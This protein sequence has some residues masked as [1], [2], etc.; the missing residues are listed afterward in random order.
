MMKK[1]TAAVL[2]VL[3]M[4]SAFVFTA[5]AE[6]IGFKASVSASLL[7]VDKGDEVSF[8]VT[9]N[10]ITAEGGLLGV[11]IPFRYDT[12]VFEFVSLENALPTAWEYA[13]YTAPKSGLLYLRAMNMGDSFTADAGCKDSGAIKFT[14]KLRVL[15]DAENSESSVT[16]AD[17][18]K[19]NIVRG[20]AADGK[21]SVVKGEGGSVSLKVGEVK[22]VYG[23]VNFDGQ[24]N[25]A[26]ASLV[27]QYDVKIAQLNDTQKTAAEVSGDGILNAA[28][29]SLILQYNVKLIKVF[30]VESK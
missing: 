25:A 29:A 9:V 15:A 7:S 26:D 4:C 3:I 22:V 20:T 2:A 14:V 30:P 23:D 8:T 5:S 12:S 18:G 28:D 1:L 13:G 24:I 19:N 6:S 27:L 21:A 10:S 11:D 17:D 16:I